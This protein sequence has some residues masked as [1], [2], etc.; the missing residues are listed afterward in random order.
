MLPADRVDA[1]ATEG[2]DDAGG[3]WW[4]RRRRIRS[5]RHNRSQTSI[6]LTTNSHRRFKAVVMAVIRTCN[7]RGFRVGEGKVVFKS[8]DNCSKIFEEKGGPAPVIL[9]HPVV[10]VLLLYL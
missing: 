1:E 7:G 6:P 8:S 3:A 2:S 5:I 9:G 4:G 10:F